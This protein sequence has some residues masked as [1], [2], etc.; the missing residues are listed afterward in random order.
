MVLPGIESQE[1][2]L[3]GPKK[4]THQENNDKGFTDLG[5]WRH[6]RDTFCSPSCSHLWTPCSVFSVTSSSHFKGHFGS[7][8]MGIQQAAKPVLS[9]LQCII[10]T[11]V[12]L[13][14]RP[15]SSIKHLW[16]GGEIEDYFEAWQ[17]GDDHVRIKSK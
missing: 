1:H 7:G 15:A 17:C 10:I 6:G 9:L 11:F 2:T 13:H 8:V 3:A 5:H 4:K 14:C 12:L 16:L